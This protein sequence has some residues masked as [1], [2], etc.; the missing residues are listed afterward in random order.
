MKT[1]NAPSARDAAEP[2]ELY[3]VHFVRRLSAAGRDARRGPRAPVPTAESVYVP[4]YPRQSR[5]CTAVFGEP[6]DFH[7]TEPARAVPGEGRRNSAAEH[8]ISLWELRPVH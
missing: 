3:G 7:M 8:K 1:A 5:S 2:N 6:P 4:L